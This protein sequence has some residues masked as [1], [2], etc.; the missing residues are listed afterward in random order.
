MPLLPAP[1]ERVNPARP[2]PERTEPLR[3]SKR[4]PVVSARRGVRRVP[5]S[6]RPILALT[7]E[8][9]DAAR[10]L[11]RPEVWQAA[12]EGCRV[13]T[14]PDG[15][16]LRSGPVSTLADRTI[17]DLAGVRRLGSYHG[18]RSTLSLHPARFAIDGHMHTVH[19]ES[20]L[21]KYW[22]T[23]AD[24]DP[25][26]LGYVGQGAVLAW[27]I[28]D[29]GYITHFIDIVVQ[30]AAGITLVAVK[31][32][33]HIVEYAALLLRGLMPATARAHG[34]GHS[35]CGSL[36][37]QTLVNLRTLGALR[38]KAPVA[39]ESWWSPAPANMAVSVGRLTNQWGGGPLGRG[40]VLRA[41]AQCHLDID[42]SLPIR[43]TTQAVWR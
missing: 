26:V 19:A 24:R 17:L 42:L 10:R 37:E 22:M 28:G 4:R 35:L 6:L 2:C 25:N 40:R 1:L 14:S 32:D 27:P 3:A 11:G 33:L 18:A 7:L 34:L 12:I 20:M 39:A 21:E 36:D 31:P 38:W 9:K 41:L 29:E 5:E 15:V 13:I 8:R 43:T 16:E 30:E 23:L